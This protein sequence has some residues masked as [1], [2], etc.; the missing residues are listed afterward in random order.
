MSVSDAAASR[1][2]VLR[3]LRWEDAPAWRQV[4]L[5]L[6][7]EV[8]ENPELGLTLQ[9]RR[10]TEAEEVAWFSDLY[11]RSLKGPDVIVVGEVDG[12]P[13]GLVTIAPARRG[14]SPWE[15]S[16]VGI[17]GILVARR[18]RGH[19][20]GEALMLRALE[21]ARGRFEWVR[22]TVFSVNSGARRLYER[23]GFRTVGHLEAEVKRNGRYL[24]EELMSLDLRSWK[25]PADVGRRATGA[26]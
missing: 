13:A 2:F 23:L 24:D 10:P 7:D 8:K 21:E 16:H 12:H 17:L 6:Y 11:G 1:R 5:D 4:Y 20:L 14:A 9:E 26:R 3:G 25:A 18:H 15:N 19:G 22:L